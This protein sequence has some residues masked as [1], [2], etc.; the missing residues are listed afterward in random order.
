MSERPA[1]KEN[2]MSLADQLVWAINEYVKAGL[3]DIKGD[4]WDED[5]DT[6]EHIGNYITHETQIFPESTA[7]TLTVA[8][9]VAANVWSAWVEMVDAPG[10]TTF[11]SRITGNA[12][13]TAVNI[14]DTSAS[15]QMWM[16]EIAYGV[17]KTMI[18][19]IRFISASIGN[20]PAITG[21]RIR[22]AHM[23]NGEIIYARLMCDS[24]GEDCKLHL[25]YYLDA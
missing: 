11:T 10:G 6:L 17:A 1:N 16:L 14:E 18:A 25:R 4:G 9:N 22:S 5:I 8:G 23:P 15:G 12:H 13:L 7:Q 19:R 20:L 3:D 21:V 2:L 24:G